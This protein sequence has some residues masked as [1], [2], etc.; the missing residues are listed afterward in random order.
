MTIGPIVEGEKAGAAVS[1]KRQCPTCG[2]SVPP[3][4]ER[5]PHCAMPGYFPNVDA[6]EAVD[7]R[8]ELA[9]RYALARD[10][11]TANGTL[12]VFA[13]LEEVVRGSTATISRD[14]AEVTRLAT[15]DRALYATYYELAYALFIPEGTK[16]DS[17]RRVVDAALFPGYHDKIRF[18]A[19]S[20]NGS[21]LRHY[22]NCTLVLDEAC[23]GHRASVFEENTCTW[24]RRQ[25][26]RMA[27][28]DQLP[29]GYRAVWADRPRLAA[30]KLHQRLQSPMTDGELRSLLLTN[31]T[32]SADDEFIEVHIYEALTIRSCTAVVVGP[33]PGVDPF[34]VEILRTKLA[35]Q[36]VHVEGQACMP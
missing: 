22:G 7:E 36:G 32:T 11:A 6:A 23:V 12:S 3:R 8:Q 15:S 20:A 31:G 2:R 18:A 28:A 19:L 14:V 29:K 26:I 35:A 25:D 13:Q 34:Q 21:G 9:S 1:D 10:H 4:V 24:A 17:L 16:W 30:A 5:C 27:D 33:C